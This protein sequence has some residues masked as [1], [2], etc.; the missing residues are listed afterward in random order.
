MLE[1]KGIPTVSTVDSAFTEIAQIAAERAGMPYV[2]NV[3]I[4]HEVLEENAAAKAKA[5]VKDIVEGLTKPLGENEKAAGVIR[6]GEAPGMSIQGTL[7]EVQEFFLKS[8]W[9]DGL[10][11]IPPTEETVRE[12]LKGTSH[13]PEKVVVEK[14][15]PEPWKVTVEKVAINGVMAG[16]KPEHM[17]ILLAMVEAFSKG[18]FGASVRSTTSFSFMTVVNGPIADKVGMNS[19]INAM[20]PGNAAN[21]CI[22]RALDLFMINL[23]GL[24]PGLN[25]TSSIGNPTKY[26]FAFAENESKS[27]WE[28]FHLG[29]GFNKNESTVSVFVGGWYFTSP[30]WVTGKDVLYDICRELKYVPLPWGATVILDPTTAK[31]L[32]KAGFSKKDVRNFLWENTT[33][34]A[35]EFRKGWG[36]D[37]FVAP[38]IKGGIYGKKTW[39]ESYLTASENTPLR[40]FFSPDAINILVVGGETYLHYAVWK[41]AFPTTVSVDKWK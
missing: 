10:P 17:P 33:M 22:G 16:C 23:G 18:P 41:M 38:S 2:R 28:P 39:P 9:T 14:F 25:D 3:I 5:A 26:S 30:G 8:R 7:Q 24:W 19:G 32:S 36:Y 27:P 31:L 13:P 34:P 21:A 15:L 1:K 29:Q 20:G 12:M 37:V 11:I 6:P 40:V 4:P 35:K